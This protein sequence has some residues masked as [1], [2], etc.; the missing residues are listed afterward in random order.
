M[1][2]LKQ[3]E[4]LSFCIRTLLSSGKKSLKTSLY[5][6]SQLWPHKIKVP[7]HKTSE[8]FSTQFRFCCLF[9]FLFWSDQSFYCRTKLLSFSTLI[10]LFYTLHLLHT[11]Y[12]K[13]IP[14]YSHTFYKK[15]FPFPVVVPN[16]VIFTHGL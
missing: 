13:I 6:V 14:F 2:W 4:N 7:F 10:H 8:A 12:M 16:S 1:S 5:N 9:P 15:L 11:V 3:K